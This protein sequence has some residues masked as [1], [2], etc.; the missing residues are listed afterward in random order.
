MFKSASIA[1]EK[2]GRAGD[3]TVI[4]RL[5]CVRYHAHIGPFSML[6]CFP[7]SLSVQYAIALAKESRTKSTSSFVSRSKSHRS[8][9][10]INSPC[11]FFLIRRNFMNFAER[12]KASKS[13]VFVGSMQ[14]LLLYFQRSTNSGHFNL[15][16]KDFCHR[17]QTPFIRRIA[18]GWGYLFMVRVIFKQTCRL[19]I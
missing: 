17:I 7:F 16:V 18:V 12:S 8:P 1:F 15:G 19:A 14:I 6:T 11:S 9:I 13:K 4:E 2:Q 5:G 3:A 10:L